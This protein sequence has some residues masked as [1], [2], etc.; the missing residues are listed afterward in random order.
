MT[1]VQQMVATR[2]ASPF[3]EMPWVSLAWPVGEG[4]AIDIQKFREKVEEL[5][6]IASLELLLSWLSSSA[7]QVPF[8]FVQCELEVCFMSLLSAELSLVL[9]VFWP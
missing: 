4:R 7:F 2:M 5:P 8:F 6:F 9:L 1:L 3:Q